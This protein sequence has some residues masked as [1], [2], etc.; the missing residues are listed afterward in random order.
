MSLTEL[1]HLDSSEDPTVIWFDPGGTTG[2]CLFSVHPESLIAN[3]VLIL[4][5]IQHWACGEFTGTEFK[6]VDDMLEL[7]DA[8]PGA[9]L[10]SEDFILR[11]FD[12]SRV[13]LAPVRL[14]AALRYAVAPRHVHLQQ[15]QLA[16]TTI[17]D[18]RLKRIGFW[19]LTENKVHA[20]DAIRHGLT[21]LKRL[22]TQR[23]LLKSVF[24]ELLASEEQE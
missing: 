19:G 6:Q 11:R 24:P 21:F 5:N 4:D 17:T 18:A 3:D 7:A 14:N 22:K 1:S 9:A 13:A 15:A 20:R 16:K 23:K 2:W 12:M 10:G 8:W